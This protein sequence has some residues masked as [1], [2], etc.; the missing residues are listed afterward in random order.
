MG[1]KKKKTKRILLGRWHQF[2]EH[3]RKA[4]SSNE[5]K[6]KFQLES[7]NS[8]PTIDLNRRGQELVNSLDGTDSLVQVVG[9]LVQG[10]YLVVSKKLFR[11]MFTG[12]PSGL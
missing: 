9:A 6:S 7:D 8:I 1:R 4:P 3:T 11:F 10:P 2:S 12:L 5:K